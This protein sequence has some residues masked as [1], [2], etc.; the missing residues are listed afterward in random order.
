MP[1]LDELKARFNTYKKERRETLESKEGRVSK[2]PCYQAR[3]SFIKSLD[4]S[5]VTD[6]VE[7]QKASN[8][9]DNKENQAPSV[10]DLPAVLES[11][12]EA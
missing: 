3:M 2:T 7:E 6:G 12:S 4:F 10:I 9:E 1:R 11:L 8:P 5:D